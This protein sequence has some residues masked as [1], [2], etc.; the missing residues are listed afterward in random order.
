MNKAIA[1]RPTGI[2]FDLD[3][4]LADTAGDIRAALN[5]TLA[6][7]GL[8]Q[9]ELDKVRLMIGRGPVV[10][11]ERA[12]RHLGVACDEQLVAELTGEFI[13]NYREHGNPLSVLV[14]GAS[15]CLDTF[16]ERDIPLGVCSNKP[17]EFCV[18]LLEDLGVRDRFAAI[19]G[20][21]ADLPKKPDPALLHKT[22]DAMNVRP[23]EA[24]YVGDSVTDVNTARAAGVEVALVRNGYSD[25]PVDTLGPDHAIS[26]LK[27]L[28]GLVG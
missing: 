10:L 2:V 9:L 17:H 24:L 1:S 28:D 18:S 27:E 7:R 13:E 16:A 23:S 11:I 15:Q 6:G 20:S 4:T 3:G 25:V 26:S 22:L 21:T 19:Q 12:L 5:A 8:E 14:D